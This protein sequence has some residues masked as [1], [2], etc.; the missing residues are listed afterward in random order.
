MD[1]DIKHDAISSRKIRW[2][3]CPI[4]WDSISIP[5]V[6]PVRWY[7]GQE[8]LP[9]QE[10]EDIVL[11][12]IMRRHGSTLALPRDETRAQE[13]LEDIPWYFPDTDVADFARIMKGSE[14]YMVEQFNIEADDLISLENEDGLMYGEKPDWTSKALSEVNEAKQR[15]IG[16]GNPPTKSGNSNEGKF[17]I[18]VNQLL[19]GE[20][21]HETLSWKN[22][23]TSCNDIKESAKNQAKGYYDSQIPSDGGNK[24]H[25][26]EKPFLFY[27]ALPHYYLSPLDIRILKSAYG[28][29]DSFPSTVVPQIEYISTGHIMDND[30]RRRM[31]YLSH[32][33][34]GCEIKLLECN[35]TNVITPEILDNFTNQIQS[36]RKK[37]H[38]K[39]IRE[40]RDRIIAER[41]E[42]EAQWAI[43][44]KHHSVESKFLSEGSF[45][46]LESSSNQSPT[47]S[48]TQNISEFSQST[49]S[50][51]S[52]TVWGTGLVAP[53]TP[54][55]LTPQSQLE[56]NDGWLHAWEA[57][58]D[59][60]KSLTA[61]T[62]ESAPEGKISVTNHANLTGQGKK[63]K[64][65]K[66]TLMSTNGK[67]AA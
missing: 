55:I 44:R 27:Q 56:E 13:K 53:V 2:K 58:L 60:E 29:F 30:L 41:A 21:C 67:R 39:E 46:R 62:K 52:K 63:K 8:N 34:Q 38:D 20:F 7:S 32:V 64:P 65:K 50:S 28:S 26:I 11:R 5:E 31:K 36:R 6:R 47:C 16:I 9:L 10:A 51:I 49:N 33:P 37:N 35:W 18:K 22:S 59:I 24:Q 23:M 19:D 45:R 3:N 57:E 61:G 66:I 14:D 48:E 42:D 12:L 54:R 40:E 25:N 4:C 1:S 17:K 15:I 43:A